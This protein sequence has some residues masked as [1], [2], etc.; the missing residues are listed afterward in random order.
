MFTIGL[1]FETVSMAWKSTLICL[2]YSEVLFQR[3]LAT[4]KKNLW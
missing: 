1:K 4:L 2:T 3:Y